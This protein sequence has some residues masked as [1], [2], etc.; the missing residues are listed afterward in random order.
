MKGMNWLRLA[1]L[2]LVI[3]CGDGERELLRQQEHA[4]QQQLARKQ[5]QAA[6]AEY[7]QKTFAALDHELDEIRTGPKDA[8]ARLNAVLAQV[9]GLVNNYPDS[10]LMQLTMGRALILSDCTLNRTN[11]TLRAK[12]YLD[13][14]IQLHPGIVRTRVLLAH[15]A[16]NGGCLPCAEQHIYAAQRMAPADPYVLEAE[17]RRMH[18]MG[19]QDLAEKLYLQA[20]DAFP[21]P[22]KRF[23]VYSWLSGIY[24]NREEYDKAEILLLKAFLSAPDGAF[25]NENLGRFYL[26]TRGDF[27]RAIPVLR[28]TV[29]NMRD[30]RVREHLAIA[31]Y[32]RWADAYLRKLDAKA[33]AAFWEEAQA[34]SSDVRSVFLQ[35]AAYVGTGRATRALLETKRIP[36]ATVDEIGEQGRTPLLMA[37]WNE[38]S[39]LAVFLLEHGANPNARDAYGIYAVHVAAMYGDLK[40]LEALARRK[41]NF[42]VLSQE[43]RETALMQIART[44]KGKP[45]SLKV[46]KLLIDKGVP[47]NAKAAHGSTALRY[48]IGAR[49]LDMV[50][51]LI[52]RG[53]DV[54]EESPSGG[55]PIAL[56]IQLGDRDMVEELIVGKADL[57]RKVS[58]LTLAEFAI[59]AGHPELAAMFPSPL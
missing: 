12:G 24:Q 10:P 3:S 17:G 44:G 8:E 28:R 51:Y 1:P 13:K 18:L 22:V 11:C 41:A 49:N 39:D 52:A 21:T 34:G 32:E 54:N 16:M 43:A 6:K 38:S 20:I 9:E 56:A 25:T 5:E 33:V 42:G 47:V 27:D 4:R 37:V 35:S 2:L 58:G 26:L 29:R 59:K 7:L 31:L 53:A 19:R 50:R 45:N 36:A 55:P 46:A 40:V 15:D 48:A 57:K 23:Q 14:A 30:P